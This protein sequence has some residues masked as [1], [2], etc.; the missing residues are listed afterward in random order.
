[1]KKLF[2]LILAVLTLALP[3]ISCGNTGSAPGDDTGIHSGDTNGEDTGT[4]APETEKEVLEIPDEKFTDIDF[5]ILVNENYNWNFAAADFDEPSDEPL[6][7]ALY[8][9]NIA[10]EEMLGCTIS[11]S[12]STTYDSIATDFQTAVEAGDPDAFD[13]ASLNLLHCGT[14]VGAG[15]CYDLSA[16]QYLDL[17]KSWW[18][19]NS[20]EQLAIGGKNYMVGGDILYSDKELLWLIFFTKQMI[21]DLG[22]ENPYELVANNQWT[23]DKMMEMIGKAAYDENANGVYDDADTY[24]LCTH[25]YHYPAMWVA[26]EQR[27]VRLDEDGMPYQTWGEESFVTAYEKIVELSTMEGVRD[28]SDAFIITKMKEGK[29]LFA[30]EVVGWISGYR[31]NEYDFGLLPVPKYSADQKEYYTLAC[32]QADLLVV[33]NNQNDTYSTGIILEA[34][35]AKGQEI[36]TP[37]YYEKQ[38][39]SRHSRDEESSA[40]LDIIFKNRVYDIGTMFNWGN[41]SSSLMASGGG[42]P[43]ALYAANEKAFRKTMEKSLEKILG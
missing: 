6:E 43:T 31:D 41:I 4:S 17:S 32:Q 11:Q 37:T 7:N 19:I 2:A 27:L 16:F 34:M 15:R 10:V 5:T 23:W 39:Q 20:V 29:T 26:A 35:A 33:G 8:Q 24:G 9:R 36:M 28:N 13:A 12:V 40:M 14:N 25:D 38:L 3:L 1:M 21:T 18:D 42:N 30:G 22:L